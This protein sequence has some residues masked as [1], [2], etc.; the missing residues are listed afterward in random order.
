MQTT[1]LANYLK[2]GEREKIH[3]SGKFA[4]KNNPSFKINSLNK[5]SLSADNEKRCIAS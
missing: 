1:E 2:R 5:A 3:N 4:V